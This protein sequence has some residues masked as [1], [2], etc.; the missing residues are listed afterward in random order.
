MFTLINSAIVSLQTRTADRQEGQAMIEYGLLA[1][2]VA[3][4]AVV[5]ATT[6][7]TDLSTLFTNIGGK[8]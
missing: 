2:V 4:V 3:L 7:G 6:L 5:G 8:L 1:A